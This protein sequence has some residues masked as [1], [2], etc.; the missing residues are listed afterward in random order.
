MEGASGSAFLVDNQ[1]QSQSVAVTC[2]DEI[3]RPPLTSDK[4]EVQVL[5]NESQ[6]ASATA[7]L[8]H[9]ATAKDGTPIDELIFRHPKT[10]M[11]VF[12]AGFGKTFDAILQSIQLIP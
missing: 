7:R 2:Q 8:Y 1:E 6:T 11:D 5:Y 3:P 12:I 9:D 4:I 10:G